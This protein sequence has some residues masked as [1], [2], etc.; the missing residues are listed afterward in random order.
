MVM[1]RRLL[2]VPPM[3]PRTRQDITQKNVTTLF[4]SKDFQDSVARRLSEAV[5]IP[6]ITYDSMGSVGIDPRWEVF[7]KFS[8]YLK[9]TFP[10]VYETLTVETVSTHAMLYTWHGSMEGLKPLLFMGHSDVVPAGISTT[11]EW[12]YPPFSGH[13]DGEFIWGRGSED[14][15]SNLIAMLTAIDCLLSCD[16]NPLRTVILAVGFDEE[17]GADRSYGARCLAETLLERYGKDGVELIFDEGIAGIENRFGTDFALPATAEKGYVDVTVQIGVPGGH[18][19]T[20][21][22]H[23]A[24]GFLAQIIRLIEDQPFKS[25]LVRQNPTLTYLR[26]AALLSKDMPEDLRDAISGSRSSKKLLEYMDSDRERRAMVRTSI[27]VDVIQG[28]DK[29][30]SLPENATVLVNHRIAIHDSVQV[31]KDQYV[32]LLSPWAKKWHF[33]LDAFGVK[34]RNRKD[35]MTRTDNNNDCGDLTLT[36]AYEL[37]PSPVS[38]VDDASFRWL[39]GTIKGVF[40]EDVVVAP[41]LLS[42]NTDTRYYWDLSPHIYRMSP[43]RA[44]DDPRGTRMHTVDERMPVKGLLEMVKFY[45]EFIRVLDEVQR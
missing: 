30:N 34:Q 28:G 26:Q 32:A 9:K 42:G 31:V 16:F 5:Q 10:Q 22:D 6:T 19:S 44:K 15:K 4:E 11:A 39:A 13:Y 18:S 17:G 43:W 41:E 35:D 25:Q 33:N 8:D 23:T 36:A 29:I 24:I 14:D 1:N 38:D 21:P 7:F 45:H 2:Q 27:A 3:Y 20:P 12:S 37:D 40:G